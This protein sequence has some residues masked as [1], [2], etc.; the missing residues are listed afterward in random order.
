MLANLMIFS[1]TGVKYEPLIV[2]KYL[3]TRYLTV[4]N[5]ELGK[6]NVF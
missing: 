2:Q 5:R 4:S 3:W 1:A 6:P